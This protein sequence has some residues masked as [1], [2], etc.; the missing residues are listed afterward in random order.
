MIDVLI[1]ILK[2]L[3]IAS[4]AMLI[5]YKTGLFSMGRVPS[6]ICFVIL[7]LLTA[8]DLY[9]YFCRTD[10]TFVAIFKSPFLN[11]TLD[12]SFFIR[13]LLITLLMGLICSV[14]GVSPSAKISTVKDLC[15]L[16]VLIAITVILAVYGTIRVGSAVKISFKFISV[17][18]TAA[19]FGPAWGGIVGALA[20][21]IAF[22]INPAGG[23]FIP[24]ITAV[25]FLYGFT[26]GLFF[27][28]VRQW[29]GFKSMFNIIVCVILQITVLNLWLT[30]NLLTPIMQM[31]FNNLLVY[32]SISGVINMAIQLV[33]ISV[34]TK[35]I[36]SFRKILK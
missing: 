20:D 25:E 1:L 22:M 11:F 26:Y 34:M 6:I 32:R 8:G 17:F 27:F 2:V 28:N 3:I 4:L 31:S 19:I 30:T 12:F 10:I 7:L 18:I 9:T 36:S 5:G 21:V 24:Q 23:P 13:V 29:N 35:Y 15:A 33:V 16:A 14:F